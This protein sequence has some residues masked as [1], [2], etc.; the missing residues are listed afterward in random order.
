MNDQPLKIFKVEACD[1][2]VYVKAPTLRA[3][4]AHITRV[5][6]WVPKSLLTFTEVVSLP[7]NEI[8]L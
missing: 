2:V 4:K 7:K 3:A 8:Y 6:G 5:V 1:D